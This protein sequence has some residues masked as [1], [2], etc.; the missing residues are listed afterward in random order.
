MLI[1]HKLKME[2]TGKETTPYVEVM[3]YDQLSRV[4]EI[5]MLKRQTL[6]K[7]HVFD[8]YDSIG[9]PLN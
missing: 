1:K 5:T 7:Y 8:T 3:Q 6:D 4:L 2:L 9:C